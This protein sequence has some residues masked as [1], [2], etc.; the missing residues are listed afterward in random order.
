MKVTAEFFF[1]NKKPRS[2]T[3]YI[4]PAR[5]SSGDAPDSQD[6]DGCFMTPQLFYSRA[7]HSET[8]RK[9]QALAMMACAALDHNCE[10]C[11]ARHHTRYTIF[12]AAAADASASTL[13]AAAA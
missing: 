1:F 12:G 10:I 3:P 9:A 5:L 6:M 11:R 2:P 4:T 8:M 7:Y 13:T